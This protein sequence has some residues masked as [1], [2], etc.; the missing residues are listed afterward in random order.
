M[1]HVICDYKINCNYQLHCVPTVQLQLHLQ[2]LHKCNQ[3][4]NYLQLRLQHHFLVL[5][6]RY[7]NLLLLWG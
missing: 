7:S 4:Q 5:T 3:L 1:E 2:L 6:Q